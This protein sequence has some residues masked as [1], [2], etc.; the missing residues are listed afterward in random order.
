MPESD[1]FAPCAIA[2]PGSKMHASA[3]AGACI[4]KRALR[5]VNK[6]ILVCRLDEGESVKDSDKDYR[7]RR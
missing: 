1:A 5:L 6:V 2:A 3:M 7:F 4:G